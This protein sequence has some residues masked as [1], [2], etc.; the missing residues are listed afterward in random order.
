[1]NRAASIGGGHACCL[2][3]TVGHEVFED[4]L[5]LRDAKWVAQ[6]RRVGERNGESAGAL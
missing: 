1:M 6:P 3:V 5:G 2:Q 4:L